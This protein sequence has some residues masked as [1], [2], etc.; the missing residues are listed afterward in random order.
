MGNKHNH[1]NHIGSVHRH[2]FPDISPQ[3]WK[4]E[5]KKVSEE[6]R[7]MILEAAVEDLEFPK[8]FPEKQIDDW[9]A[10]FSLF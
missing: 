8:T 1:N 4:L 7:R 3:G 10:E 9:N 6:L 2:S 5:E